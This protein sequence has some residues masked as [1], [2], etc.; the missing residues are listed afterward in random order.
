MHL[1]VYALPS[2]AF[3]MV[4]LVKSLELL[5]RDGSQP[6]SVSTHFTEIRAQRHAE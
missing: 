1:F 3:G 5:A 6:S 4:E 2:V